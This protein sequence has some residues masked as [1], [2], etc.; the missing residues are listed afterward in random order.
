MPQKGKNN[1]GLGRAIIN[2]KFGGKA[3][4]MKDMGGASKRRRNGDGTERVSQLKKAFNI[5][6]PH[7]AKIFSNS[8]QQR[9]KRPAG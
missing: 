4:K 6:K 8:T 3:G 1:E 7:V 2:A 5:A 9:R